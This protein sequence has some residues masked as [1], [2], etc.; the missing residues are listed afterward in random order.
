MQQRSVVLVL[1]VLILAFG[2]AFATS[3]LASAA[4]AT[5]PRSDVNFAPE[6]ST[7]P[8]ICDACTDILFVCLA[9]NITGCGDPNKCSALYQ[10]CIGQLVCP[11]PF[12]P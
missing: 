9:C 2:S 10:Q 12:L 4:G 7:I 5:A 8:L 6:G 11:D 1:A 3:Q